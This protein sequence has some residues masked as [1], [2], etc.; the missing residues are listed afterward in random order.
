MDQLREYVSAVSGTYIALGHPRKRILPSE[1]KGRQNATRSLVAARDI[2]AGQQIAREDL[3][4][5]R[6]GNGISPYLLDAV[7]GMVPCQ[8]IKRNSVLTWSMFHPSAAYGRNQTAA[9]S[10]W[11]N[12]IPNAN[13]RAK[14]A[15]NPTE[16][17]KDG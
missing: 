6:P 14:R 9:Q 16:D 17:S 8:D 13:M 2:K 10:P 15:H 11:P 5:L 1:Q 4:V 3:R 12:Q 7:V